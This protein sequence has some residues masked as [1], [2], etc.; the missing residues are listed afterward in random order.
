V[1][2]KVEQIDKLYDKNENQ[3][4]KQVKLNEFIQFQ[5]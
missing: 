5:F 4:K 2:D 1:R 3:T